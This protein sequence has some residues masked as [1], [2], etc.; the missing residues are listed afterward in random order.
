[1]AAGLQSQ[2]FHGSL[3][4]VEAE[5]RLEGRP[6]GTFLFRDS[7]SRKGYSLSVRAP[8]RIKHYIVNYNEKTNLYQLVG[9]PTEFEN[10][11]TLVEFYK[12]NPTSTTDGTCL[13]YACPN[14]QPAPA[15]EPTPSGIPM[16]D[17][18]NYV[19]LVEGAGANKKVMEEVRELAQRKREQR[20]STGGTPAGQATTGPK[21]KP[22]YE[23]HVPDA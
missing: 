14:G 13:M 17:D 10:I 4:R 9:K 8:D 1:M 6:V 22:V 18:D 21:K 3:S 23:D 11:P 5:A 12:S 20:V 2:W 16:G 15:P 19:A 7:E